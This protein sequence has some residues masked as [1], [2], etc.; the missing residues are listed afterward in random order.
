MNEALKSANQELVS[1]G[2]KIQ[3]LEKEN[4]FLRKEL[5][6]VKRKKMEVA[7][8]KVFHHQLDG[9]SSTS[10]IDVGKNEGVKVGMPVIFNGEILFGVIKE[11]YADSSLIYLITDPR[12]NLSVKIENSETMGRS[13]GNLSNG[14]NLELVANQ[15]EITPGQLVITSGLDGLPSAL[16]VGTIKTAEPSQGGL[17]Q[18]ILV[19]PKFQDQTIERVFV[20]K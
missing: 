12:V 16:V 1:T 18:K 14:L 4:D 9:Q 5:G 8:A 13:K 17:F 3:E 11:V 7:L 20:L 19:E 15:E 2:L 6:V 10:L